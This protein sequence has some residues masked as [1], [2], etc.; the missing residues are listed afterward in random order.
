MGATTTAAFIVTDCGNRCVYDG[1][2]LVAII[3]YDAVDGAYALER[4][5]GR[6]ERHAGA[7]ER[8]AALAALGYNAERRAQI[9]AGR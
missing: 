2:D 4:P 9:L 1:T 5:S 3:W 7:S 6:I 8:E